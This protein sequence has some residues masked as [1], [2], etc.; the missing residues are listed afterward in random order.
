MASMPRSR[1]RGVCSQLTHAGP[2]RWIY[3]L[4]QHT[5][6]PGN[7]GSQLAISWSSCHR[8]LRCRLCAGSALIL[9]PFVASLSPGLV[10]PL[11]SGFSSTAPSRGSSSESLGEMSRRR[12]FSRWYHDDSSKQR[13]FHSSSSRQSFCSFRDTSCSLVMWKGSRSNSNKDRN[14]EH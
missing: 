3:S 11:A 2:F 7:V 12:L 13:R 8:W 6:S 9:S 10:S 14:S 4:Y 1:I 5:R